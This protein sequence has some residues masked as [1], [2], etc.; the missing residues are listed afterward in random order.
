MCWAGVVIA[1][2]GVNGVSVAGCLGY[3]VLVKPQIFKSSS[4][5]VS[6]AGCLGYDVLGLNR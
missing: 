4:F 5:K 1:Y 3:D 6:V 2:I